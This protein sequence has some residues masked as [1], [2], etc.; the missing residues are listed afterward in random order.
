M[1][2]QLIAVRME[3]NGN[4]K[5]GVVHVALRTSTIRACPIVLKI[6]PI[7]LVPKSRVLCLLVSEVD[8]L[9]SYVDPLILHFLNKKNHELY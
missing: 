6:L 8:L 4:P 7:S 3:C 9:V 2:K 5:E 1:L